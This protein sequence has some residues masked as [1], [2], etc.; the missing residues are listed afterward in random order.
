MGEKEAQF[1]CVTKEHRR[2]LKIGQTGGGEETTTKRKYYLGNY[3]WE[4]A[5]NY[6][7]P[8][9]FPK[10]FNVSTLYFIPRT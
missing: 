6:Y 7:K 8:S 10:A 4:I 5:M 9:F 3:Y 1:S 2:F